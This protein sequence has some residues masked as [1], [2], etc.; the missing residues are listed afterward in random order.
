MRIL[1]V[2]DEP[3]LGRLLVR[4]LVEEGHP[5]DLASTGE[6]ALWMASAAPYDAIVLDVM[7]PGA[8]GFTICGELRARDVWTPVLMLT[9]RDTIEDKIQGLDT[10]ADDYLIKPFSFSEL[11]ARLRALARRA[12]AERPS[13]LRVGD[14][15]LD[16]ARHRAWRE[17]TELDLTAKE[18]V[19]LEVFMRRPGEALSR[20]QL[21]DAAWDIAFESRSNVVDVYVR[22][23][24]EKIDRPFG[25]SSL[26]TVRGVGY[27]LA[28]G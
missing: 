10:G 23:L 4:G 24:R 15:R 14:L 3:K 8:D 13:E 21:L 1:V 22:Y 7:L 19:L 9:A 28:A 11:L 6:D 26:E 17:E 16:P 5:T 18:F 25:R 12:P 20:V 27:R 2:E